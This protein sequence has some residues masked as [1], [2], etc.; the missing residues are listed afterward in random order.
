MKAKNK[1][2]TQNINPNINQ[3]IN[4]GKKTFFHKNGRVY[5]SK[6]TERK[7]FFVLTI[8]MLVSGIFAKF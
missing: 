8:I 1:N 4:R 2:I 6:D 7:I 5:F 3:N